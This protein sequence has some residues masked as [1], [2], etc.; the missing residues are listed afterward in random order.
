[1]FV[2]R[3]LSRQTLVHLALITALILTGLASLSVSP[4]YVFAQEPTT[5]FI[6]EIHYDNTGAD[7]DEA[8]E[9]AG[10]AGVDLTGWSLVLYNGNGGAVYAT[11]SL[12]GSI[13]D[14]GGGFGVVV[15]DTPGLQN[16]APDG[17]ALVDNGAVIQ[18]LSYEGSFTAVDGPAAGTTSTDIAV[19]EPGDTPV[20]FSLQLA[21]TGAVYQDFTWSSAAANTFGAFNTGQTFVGGA[22]SG[23]LIN[24]FVF[25]HDGSDVNEYIEVFGAAN[26]D[27]AGLTLV[28]IEGDS[29]GPGVIDTVLT[30]GATDASGFWLTGFLSN[31][32][33]NGTISLLL[34]EGFS[35]SLGADLDANDDGTLDS[36]PWTS[37]LDSVAI[38]DDGT[39]DL[40]YA[41]VVLT[42]NYDGL[43]SFAPGG[44][45]RIPNGA[46]TGSAGDWVRNDFDRAGIAGIGGTPVVGEA[47]NTPGTANALFVEEPPPPTECPADVMITPIY[48]VQGSDAASPL[49]GQTVT[50]KGVVT[51]DFQGTEALN[52]FF[53]QEQS[54]D[55]LAETSDGVFIYVPPANAFSGIDVVAGDLVQVTGQVKEFNTLTE[56]DFVSALGICAQGLA[57]EP[58]P[59]MLPETFDGQLEQ[60]EG[61]LVVFNQT[62]TV[63]Q[64]FFQGRYGQVTL[65]AG[66]RLF[67]PT[68]SFAPLSP[69]AIAQAD[70]NARRLLVLDDGQDINALGDNPSPIPYIGANNTLR[71]GDTVAGL[72][73]VI[74]YGRINSDSS[75]PAR[76]YRL[77]PTSEPVFA[78]VNE[79]SSAPDP[80]GGNVKVASFNVLN[81]FTTIDESG[82]ACFP[83]GA[84]SDCRGA[85]SPEEFE[86]QAAK[87]VA[88]LAAIDADVVGLIEIEN[89][90]PVAVNDLVA[91]LNDALG[92][93]VYA[94]IADPAN[95]RDVPGG[96]DAIKVAMIY[97]PAVVTPV[98][99]A[100]TVDDPAFSIGRA[101]LAQTFSLAANEQAIFTVMVNHF[102]SKGCGGAT[103]ADED[104]GDGQGC[105]N[106][107]RTAQADAILGF[108]SALQ[109]DTG[110]GDVLVIGDL[111]AYGQEDPIRTLG[112]GGLVDEL[113]ARIANPYSFVFDGQAGYLDHALSTSSLS[114][115]VVGVTEWHINTDEPSVIDYNTEFKPQDLYEPTPYRSS[116]HDPVVV[117][118]EVL[119]TTLPVTTATVEG[120]LKPGTDLY[121]TSA[122]VTLTADEAATT[123]Y[124][125]NAAPFASYTAPLLIREEG[126]NTVA[127]FSVDASG[128][129]EAPQEIVVNITTFPSTGLLD[130]FSSGDVFL[131]GDWR[132]ISRRGYTLV[133]QQVMVSGG[134]PVYWLSPFGLDQEAFLTLSSLA[135]GRHALMLKAQSGPGDRG[136]ILVS[137]DA[138]A[139]AVVVEIYQNWSWR[140]IN[141]Y[142]ITLQAGDQ[143]GARALADGTVRVYVNC[144]FIG[145]A[146]AGDFFAGRDGQIG[147]WFAD[148]AGATFDDFGGGDV[149]LAE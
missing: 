20:G 27:Y 75:N 17:L 10:P 22:P 93:N 126:A 143:L 125:V 148:A 46:D 28:A 53:I 66:G 119:D 70:E 40:T 26:T 12:S 102:K 36:T 6:N 135:E 121:D 84:R 97:K 94:A 9:I 34:V 18:F 117:G 60:H 136:G 38:N 91:R 83:S 29:S 128:N 25:N 21:G 149:A 80:L 79:R 90:G 112:D 30:V 47:L 78:R 144:R 5:V 65:A 86:R 43:S 42:P 23:P 81:Y 62:L 120:V 101:P 33:E 116:D 63:S 13:A 15:V 4:I 100:V 124:R 115:Q 3:L 113:A 134:G 137:Y 45:S 110:D 109:A 31:A 16:G 19:A 104:Q 35:G 103:G 72:T 54:G 69:E 106:A 130:D 57:V 61:M 1:M 111:N 14:Q 98:G 37:V 82:A 118:L 7:T 56:I 87:I 85:D 55:G 147:F 122:T 132:G 129:E 105:Y 138:A 141:S 131:R 142:P 49:A 64:N 68:N 50:V 133:D 58:T 52:G 146:D 139:Q 140:T 59:V 24:E 32:F 44:A 73:G 96:D 76:D 67:Q 107:T 95:L 99:A 2:V 145:A 48:A 108:V 88:A 51:G 77:H 123:F 127:F 74:D 71:A 89:N 39:G 8:V 11:I 114:A 92:A 41:E